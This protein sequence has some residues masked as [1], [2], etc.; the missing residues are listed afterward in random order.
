MIEEEVEVSKVGL[1]LLYRDKY[2]DEAVTA[3]LYSGQLACMRFRDTFD[4][5]DSRVRARVQE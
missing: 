2:R 3:D 1:V 4:I 5:L